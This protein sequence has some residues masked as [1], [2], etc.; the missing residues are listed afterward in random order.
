MSFDPHLIK[1]FSKSPY[2]I[3]RIL[4]GE[5]LDLLK[6]PSISLYSGEA[7]HL[8]D[9]WSNRCKLLGSWLVLA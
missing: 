4:P 5:E 2:G 3:V 1:R 7:S 6:S 9:E 8:D